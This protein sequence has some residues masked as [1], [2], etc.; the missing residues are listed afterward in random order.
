MYISIIEFVAYLSYF[1][2]IN[3]KRAIY[4]F[5]IFEFSIFLF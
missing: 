5:R 3:N 1:F 4:E 2:F